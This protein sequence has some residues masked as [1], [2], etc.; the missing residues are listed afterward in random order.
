MKTSVLTIG[1]QISEVISHDKIVTPRI[2]EQEKVNRFLDTINSTRI[3]IVKMTSNLN[4]LE[5][6]F[7]KLSWLDIQNSEEELL[8]KKVITQAKKY[9]SSSIKNYILLKKTLWNEGICKIEIDNYKD[10]MD[11]FEDTVL[12]IEQIFFVLRKDDEFN[13]IID[14][15]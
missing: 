7:T 10:S 4:H 14:S 11:D 2:S 15:I 5:E 6:L 8:V 12:E 9:H 3:K 13:D 1:K